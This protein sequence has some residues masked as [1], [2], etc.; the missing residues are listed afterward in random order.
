[1]GLYFKLYIILIDQQ[2]IS[3]I[4]EV[5]VLTISANPFTEVMEPPSI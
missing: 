3:S 4:I 5:H 2:I 1:M